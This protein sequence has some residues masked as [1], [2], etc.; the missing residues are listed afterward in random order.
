MAFADFL[1]LSAN[2]DKSSGGVA[3]AVPEPA[4]YALLLGGLA[5]LG[6]KRRR[7]AA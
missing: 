2:F 6:L 3:A 7:Q 1:E 5:A 4:S